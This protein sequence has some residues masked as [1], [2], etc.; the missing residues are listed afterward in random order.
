M[1]K[2]LIALA[3][4][5]SIG[6]AVTS[7]VRRWLGESAGLR[8]VLAGAVIVALPAA[9][10]GQGVAQPLSPVVTGL[11]ALTPAFDPRVP[12]YVV[13]CTKPVRMSFRAPPGV[14]VSVDGGRANRGAFSASVPL[15]PGQGFRFLVSVAHH[16]RAYDVRCLPGSFPGWSANR[17][18]RPQAA[19]YVVAP[20]CISD[21]AAIYD[22]NGVPVWWLRTSRPVLDD[23]LLP[24]GDVAVAL[25]DTGWS[26]ATFDEYRLDGSFVRTFSIPTGIPTDRH[27]LQVLPNGDYIVV[28]HVPRA[29]VDL[30]PYGGPANATV[31]DALIAE[32]SP[33]HQLVWSWD[34]KDHIS[35]AET[36]R[37]YQR[38]VL[39]RPIRISGGRL[40]YDIVH[41]NAV[42]PYGRG[43]LV[44]LRHTDAAYAIDKPSGDVV[45]KLGGTPTSRSLRIIGDDVPDFGGQ[46][47][48]RALPDGTVT[49]FDNGTGR[50]RASRAL[51]FR[52]DERTRT[53]TVIEQLVDQ[54]TPP[55]SPCC[56]SARKLPGGDWVVSWGGQRVVTELTP[57]DKPV[58]SLTFTSEVSYRA[59]PVLPGVIS[60]TALEAAMDEMHP[61]PRQ[62]CVTA[63]WYC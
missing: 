50:G 15:S 16:D 42:A 31:L 41:I 6:G 18:G 34:S 17:F 39:A 26:L 62:G 11:P 25:S 44:S 33:R 38:G 53:A 55:Y 19:W 57:A 43:F 59:Q 48:V 14:A 61:R 63:G 23:S 58:F 32:I 13:G 35:L 56:G 12:D 29:G 37:W 4:A 60:R 49:L 28:A 24:D 36:G 21:Y 10:A 52:V 8:I 9:G 2:G 51:R 1:D 20:C 46:H 3:R 27:E 40:A 30:R 47:D 22:T 5:A 54:Q 45:W 7:A